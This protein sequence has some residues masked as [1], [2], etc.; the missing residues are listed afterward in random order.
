MDGKH[1]AFNYQKEE[2]HYKNKLCGQTKTW[3]RRRNTN[4]TEGGATGG[5]KTESDAEVQAIGETRGATGMCL[6]YSMWIYVCQL[7][8][9]ILSS[10]SPPQFSSGITYFERPQREDFP[11]TLWESSH[12][13][14]THAFLQKLG[15]RNRNLYSKRR[16]SQ[17]CFREAQL[18]PVDKYSVYCSKTTVLW[19]PLTGK[20]TELN[21]N[22]I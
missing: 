22:R 13:P 3:W 8:F 14:Y 9:T 21:I 10:H 20:Y 15:W 4:C 12:K 1:I 18:A 6:I 19:K 17:V 2:A 16:E 5:H 7:P 11:H